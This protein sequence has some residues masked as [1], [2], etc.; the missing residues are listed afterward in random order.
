VVK[1]IINKK[2]YL[3]HSRERFCDEKIIIVDFNKKSFKF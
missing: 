1:K 3:L 2:K